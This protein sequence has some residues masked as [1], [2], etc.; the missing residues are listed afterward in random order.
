MNRRGPEEG[1]QVKTVMTTDNSDNMDALLARYVAG[2]LPLP[3]NVLVESH[4]QI[5]PDNRALV[6]GLEAIGGN[7]L[8]GEEAIE[9]KDRENALEAVFHSKPPAEARQDATPGK[10]FPAALR[11]FT[12][13]DADN[14]PWRSKLPGFRECDL[15]EFD[16]CNASLL[17]IKPG[18]AMPSHTHEGTELT[19]VL[20]G[21]FC[22]ETGRYGRGDISV[23]DQ[24]VD[25]RP[26]AEEGR[27]CICFAVTDAP[28][29]LTG[30]LGRR[31]ADIVGI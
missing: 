9:L 17:W 23:A 10:V 7:I 22:D 25:H 2:R 1:G 5:K 31:L 14:V 11:D 30:S 24:S 21:A 15:G 12:G 8:E 18:R 19:I 4:L 29:R 6:R 27:P 20:D 13:F 16:G 28:L 3:A 26:V